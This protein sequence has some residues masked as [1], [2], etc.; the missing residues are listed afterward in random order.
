MVI[1]LSSFVGQPFPDPPP[2]LLPTA[3][4]NKTQNKIS[5]LSMLDR[6]IITVKIKSITNYWSLRHVPKG[7]SP[8]NWQDR[9]I[10][11]SCQ[12]MKSV[13][14]N[15][16]IPDLVRAWWLVHKVKWEHFTCKT[17]WTWKSCSSCSLSCNQSKNAAA[18]RL[19]LHHCMP[20]CRNLNLMNLYCA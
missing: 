12:Q 18:S 7:R 6:Q 19:S 10:A 5:A 4:E 17:C 14:N 20:C 16:Y 2:P 3:L 8:I 11:Q 1:G 9:K 13:E 15:C